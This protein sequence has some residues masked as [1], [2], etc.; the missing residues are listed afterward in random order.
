MK[1][2][3]RLPLAVD[4]G[5]S[6]QKNANFVQFIIVISSGILS[7]S[8]LATVLKAWL[9]NRKMK[10]T[11]QIDGDKKT[12]EYEGHHLT[13]DMIAI[14]TILEKPSEVIN[15]TT[16]LDAMMRDDGQKEEGVLES[17]SCQDMLTHND[18]EQTIT[19]KPPSLLKRLIPDRL[20]R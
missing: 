13:Q 12:L 20:H 9:D 3:F 16:S 2:I 4:E 19:L 14:Q 6:T 17:N 5:T 7:S 10:L 18:N 15:V 8:T 11:I 1:N